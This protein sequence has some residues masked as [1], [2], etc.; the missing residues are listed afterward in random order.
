MVQFVRSLCKHAQKS[1]YNCDC[2]ANI[3]ASGEVQGQDSNIYGKN[4]FLK[5]YNATICEIITSK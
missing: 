1:C 5:N 4:I 3:G 2:R